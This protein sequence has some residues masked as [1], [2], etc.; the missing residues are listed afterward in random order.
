M[1]QW[2]TAALFLLPLL[3]FSTSR[4][5]DPA[6]ADDPQAPPAEATAPAEAKPAAEA[7][8][9]SFLKDVAPLFVE[10]CVGCH[11]PKKAESKYDMTTFAR[12]SKGGQVGEGFTVVPEKPDESYL[13]ELLHEDADPRMPFK[14][15][16]LPAEAIQ[17]IE[18]WIAAGAAFDGADPEADWVSLLHKMRT[19]EIPE[20]YPIALPVTAVAFSP[21]GNVVVAAGYHELTAWKTAD[22]SL[23]RRLPGTP[24]RIY[25]LAFSPDGK[26]LAT[27]SGDPGQYGLVQL[28][29][30]EPDGSATLQCELAEAADAFFAVAFSPDSKLVAAA[31]ADRSVRAWKVDDGESVLMIE[32]HADWVLDVAFSADGKQLATASR[33]KTAKVFDVEKKEALITFP[34]HA[35]TVY[36]VAFTPDGKVASGGEDKQI[37]IW[38]PAEDGKEI[39]KIGGFGGAVFR[40]LPT[41]DGKEWVACCADKTVRVFEGTKQ[42]LELKGH[43]DWVYSLAISPDG[44]TIASGAWDGGIRLWKLPE[45]EPL[46]SFIAAPGR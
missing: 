39:A 5:D 27:A 41:P 13:V 26:W 10:N 24:E 45:G 34:G 20:S 9:P 37:R 19:V 11:N 8:T 46:Q 4:A 29:K 22:G 16:P 3:A 18:S 1:R 35:A 30:A 44:Q 17:T 6:P 25:D 33:D 14:L 43:D 2:L 28:W 23:V 36:C 38:N 40:L 12:L 42:R 32:D 31:G 15:D 7:G 21:D